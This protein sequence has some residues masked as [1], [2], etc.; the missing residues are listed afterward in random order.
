MGLWRGGASLAAAESCGGDAVLDAPLDRGGGMVVT[1]GCG[2]G[3][4]SDPVSD[5]NRS[6]SHAPS[7][8]ARVPVG[9]PHGTI[10]IRAV[11]LYG[12]LSGVDSAP[13]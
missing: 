6:V 1:G 4:T 3:H 2:G 8:G 11:W 7:H 13:G 12:D 9:K 10:R 5:E